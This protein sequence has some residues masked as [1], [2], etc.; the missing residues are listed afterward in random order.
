MPEKLPLPRSFYLRRAVA[1]C[2]RLKRPRTAAD[3]LAAHG[4]PA[5]IAEAARR[6]VALGDLAAAGEAYLNASQP[7][8]ALECF[9]RARLPDGQL[10]CLKRMGDDAQIGLLLLELGRPTDA[11]PHL[12]KALH[13]TTT[14]TGRA[15]LGL[16]LSRALLMNGQH[17]QAQEHYRAACTLLP[18]LPASTSTAEAWSALGEWGQAA[19]RHDRMQEGYAQALRLLEDAGE[20]ERWQQTAQRYRK[21]A[22]ACGN[23]RLAHMLDTQLADTAH[24][25]D[26]AR[27][28]LDG[29]LWQ[30]A[31]DNLTPRARAGEKAALTLL[32]AMV[33]QPAVPLFLR[34]E[35]AEMLA[36][37]GDPRLLDPQTGDA[38]LASFA[39]EGEGFRYW[40]SIEAGRFWSGDD[41]NIIQP[42]CPFCQGHVHPGQR[43]CE[44][45]SAD[46][47]AVLNTRKAHSL[48]RVTIPY[49]YRIAR[50]PVTIAEYQ[51]FMDDDGYQRWALWHQCRADGPALFYGDDR[52]PHQNAPVCGISWYEAAAYCAWLTEQGHAAGWLPPT[53]ELRLPT[54]LEWER[55]AR[56]TD[57]RRYPWGDDEP[58][59]QR[60][61][62]I[63][64][65]MNVPAPVGCFPAGAAACGALDM[66]GN[67]GEWL[68]TLSN[69]PAALA[70]VRAVADTQTV[71]LSYN[72]YFVR[73]EDVYCGARIGALPSVRLHLYGFR[74]V[75]APHQG[76]TEE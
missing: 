53:D 31:L 2:E 60:A 46:L 71:L 37:V 70:P 72:N 57:Q 11:L 56:H 61:S 24:P 67:V 38:S 25:P 26:R 36:E 50:Y 64:E 48:Q 73:G 33:E 7:R 19:G 9:R 47:R 55:A 28:L 59:E 8:A 52:T 13:A 22:L 39:S 14:S 43:F 6:F 35:A 68:A 23:R 51:R 65:E 49:T 45:C 29:G 69:T 41:N 12:E 15:R 66:A 58:D 30:E 34:T 1:C 27:A 44:T 62:G 54:A 17:N 10:R 76:S 32:A 21:A 18:S 40:C 63:G 20:Q 3:L 5:D 16:H 75:W 4:A 74:V 42:V